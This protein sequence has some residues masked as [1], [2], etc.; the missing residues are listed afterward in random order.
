MTS[1][2]LGFLARGIDRL[3][4]RRHGYRQV[5]IDQLETHHRQPAPRIVAGDHAVR[6]TDPAGSGQSMT[7]GPTHHDL[8][9][10]DVGHQVHPTLTARQ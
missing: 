10:S 8:R 1:L 4:Q 3:S 5:S 9:F 2:A 7:Q 6:H